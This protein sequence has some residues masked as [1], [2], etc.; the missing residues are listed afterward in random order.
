MN[1]KEVKI[2]RFFE[3]NLLNADISFSIFKIP[4]GDY[5]LFGKYLIKNTKGLYTV[6]I[7]NNN[8]LKIVFTSLKVAVTWCVFHDKKHFTECKIIENLDFKLSGIDTD[9]IQHNKLL[10]KSVDEQ[11]R[12]IYYS[13]IEEDEDKKRLLIKKLNK[14]M[15]MST[16]WQNKR[17][18]AA[19]TA[20][21]R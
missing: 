8:D 12:M 7:E 20:N 21:K 15:N 6:T 14:Y 11:I 10:D 1:K 18:T 13:K 17:Y 4:K 19:K 2:E 9:I 5:F 16:E 3:N